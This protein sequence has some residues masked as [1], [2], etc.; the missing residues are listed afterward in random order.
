MK[1]IKKIVFFIESL[2]GGGAEKSLTELVEHMDKNKYDITVVT[3]SNDEVYTKRVKRACHLRCLTQKCNPERFLRYNLNRLIFLFI[4]T[5]PRKYV[6]RLIIGNGY[7]VEVA[8]C[9]GF[10]TKLIANS[11]NKN[12]KKIAFVHTDMQNNRW[13]G[14]HYENVEEELNCYKEFDSISCVSES[15]AAAFCHTFGITQPV[16]VNHNPIN[17]DAI[18]IKAQEGIILANPACLQIIS[19][20][21]LSAV[22]SFDR[23]LRIMKKL[24]E[25]G[26]LFHLLILGK[27]Q[28][29]QELEQYIV[30]NDLSAYV[31]LIGFQSNPYKYI[32]HSDFLIC[33]SLAEGFNTV[34]AEC[35]V[36]GKPVVTTDCSGMKE[37]FGEKQCGLICENTEEALFEAIK[38]VLDNPDCLSDFS[39]NC[40]ERASYFDL[41][42]C[43]KNIE[44]L[45]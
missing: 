30:E 39:N 23:L 32:L 11:G 8:C 3:E 5:A 21:R 13:T 25:D 7:D 40:C 2:D 15:V 36:L 16:L 1:K 4:N 22:K 31:Q 6:H 14:I 10:A 41:N 24:K 33:S 42:K 35:I 27:G 43:V 34:V 45:F 28:K 29:E 38:S 9:E 12:S 20:G 37:A 19:I 26:Y 17:T 18:K 44:K